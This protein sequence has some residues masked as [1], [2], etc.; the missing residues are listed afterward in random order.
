M[1]I[2]TGQTESYLKCH[3]SDFILF[4]S[5]I[6]LLPDTLSLDREGV[7][8]PSPDSREKGSGDEG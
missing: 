2:K 8:S 3:R 7:I 4:S 6:R 1:A 5:T